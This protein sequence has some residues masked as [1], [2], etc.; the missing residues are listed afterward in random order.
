MG[1]VALGAS[2]LAGQGTRL[3]RTHGGVSSP[4]A[5]HT[6][7]NRLF[8]SDDGVVAGGA[9]KTLSATTGFAMQGTYYESNLADDAAPLI[10]TTSFDGTIYE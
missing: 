6:T 5:A 10:S 3:T 2:V 7:M 9:T 8:H 1:P 4:V